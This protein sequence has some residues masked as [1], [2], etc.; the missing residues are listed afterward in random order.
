MQ[1][2]VVSVLAVGT[3]VAVSNGAPVVSCL[4][5]TAYSLVTLTNPIAATNGQ[6]WRFSS[7]PCQSI[8]RDH[9]GQA[10]RPNTAQ[11]GRSYA[12]LDSDHLGEEA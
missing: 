3:L 10:R 11:H 2:R 12:T 4:H 7:C 9:L 6:L 1:Y 5:G 8:K